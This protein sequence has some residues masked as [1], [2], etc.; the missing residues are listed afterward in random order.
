M[1]MRCSIIT[2]CYNAEQTLART[3][4][5]VL[6]QTRPVDEY[7]I[8][9]GAST[10]G[11]LD[12][13]KSFADKFD[14]SLVWISEPDSGIYDAMNKGLEHA[15]GDVIGILNADDWYT[16][17]AVEQVLKNARNV[18]PGVYYGLMRKWQDDKERAVIRE[19]HDFLWQDM[20]PHPST[21]VHWDIYRQY[22]RFD[23][24]YALAGDY[25]LM[26]RLSQQDVPFYPIDH[27]L[28]NFAVGGA[29]VKRAKQMWLETI[30]IRRR[31][32]TLSASQYLM[33]RCLIMARAFVEKFLL[34]ERMS[35]A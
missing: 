21:F 24:N 32:G 2:V 18:P 31:Y 27:I 19:H 16:P 17:E 30:Q 8:I 7:I 14:G 22:G 23:T 4:Q 12:I 9:D 10:D 11:T 26:L 13:I 6:D 28:T 29:S 15:T 34:K 35:I 5:S 1:N 20:I 3:M 33:F 25:E